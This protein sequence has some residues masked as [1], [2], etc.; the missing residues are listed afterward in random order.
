MT[1]FALMQEVQALIRLV[2]PFTRVLTLWMFG[3]QR[4]LVRR[5]EW[6]MDLPN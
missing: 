6:L 3:V 4:R 1:L 2:E 5:W